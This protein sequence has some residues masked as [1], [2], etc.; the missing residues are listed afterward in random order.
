VH[1]RIEI[2]RKKKAIELNPSL[3]K[4][5]STMRLT[6]VTSEKPDDDDQVEEEEAANDENQAPPPPKTSP[7]RPRMDLSSPE[8]VPPAR[9]LRKVV[10]AFSADES[11]V[12]VLPD[13]PS[14][15]FEPSYVKIINNEILRLPN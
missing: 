14:N 15:H 1:E 4:K 10:R 12:E 5:F 8:Q 13:T 9:S 2:E 7:V 11:V 3:F 6:Q